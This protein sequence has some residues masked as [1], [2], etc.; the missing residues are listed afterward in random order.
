MLIGN[1][2]KYRLPFERAYRKA[3]PFLVLPFYTVINFK[4]SLYG[5]IYLIVPLV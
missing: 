1:I 3:K 4:H 2:N 5:S